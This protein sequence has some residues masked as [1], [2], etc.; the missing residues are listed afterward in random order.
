MLVSSRPE[1]L[2]F[3]AG[4]TLLHLELDTIGRLCFD[5]SRR[6]ST[7]ALLEAEAVARAEVDRLFREGVESTD[8]SRVVLY[9]E[10]I[11][12]RAGAADDEVIELRERILA[13]HRHANLW[14]R[15]LD[16]TRAMLERLREDGYR[17]AV[18][19]NADGRVRELFRSAGLDDLFELI[20]DSH[21]LGIEKPDPRI[22]THA[23]EL[24]RT[25]PERSLYI[26]DIYE[27]DVVGARAAG[28]PVVLVDPLGA[29][30]YADVPTIASVLELPD[31]L[32]A[33][34]T[35]AP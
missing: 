19:S 35:T 20:V 29:H 3:D 26:G 23:C 17:L 16:G 13:R 4:G 32:E 1:I 25:T 15:V 8:S 33:G 2:F 10:T 28:M 18:I 27:I 22:F 30:R 31:W 21:E 34:R 7:D 5:E 6:P 14:T 12:Q 9:F 24:M 11:L